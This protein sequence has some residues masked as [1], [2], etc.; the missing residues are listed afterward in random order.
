MSTLRA[1]DGSIM[2]FVFASLFSSFSHS[3]VGGN[4]DDSN[5]AS[6]E[7]AA[8]IAAGEETA[9]HECYELYGQRLYRLIL[10]A[11][12]YVAQDAEDVLQDTLVATVRGIDNYRGEGT[13]FA[14]MSGI[15][16]RKA[17]SRRRRH[18]RLHRRL[19]RAIAEQD[20]V[21]PTTSDPH[22][23][24]L[25]LTKQVWATLRSLSPRYAYALVLKYV[26]GFRVEEIAQIMGCSSNAA[27]SLLARARKQF[28]QVFEEPGL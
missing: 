25:A 9:C 8:R 18:F 23:E 26:E 3:E 12:G 10:A 19:E 14:W 28:R 4:G 2:T 7:L 15:A 22:A 24:Q 16:L 27:Q 5:T 20:W 21:V 11:V 1:T 6:V 13:L 17:A